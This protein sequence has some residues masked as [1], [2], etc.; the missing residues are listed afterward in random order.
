M[1]NEAARLRNARGAPPLLFKHDAEL[2]ISARRQEIVDALRAH[3]VLIVAGETGS[4][5][6]TQLPQYCLEIGPRPRGTDRPHP[7]ATARGPRL[8]GANRRG[9]VAAA[10]DERRLSRA[11]RRSSI[12]M[13]RGWC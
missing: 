11:I 12:A 9:I 6:S 13:P 4:G 3:Q 5:K 8:G 7:A 2:P 10:R 1:A